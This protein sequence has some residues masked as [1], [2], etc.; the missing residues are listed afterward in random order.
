VTFPV[1]ARHAGIRAVGANPHPL[2]AGEGYHDW[3]LDAEPPCPADTLSAIN[4]SNFRGTHVLVGPHV[5]QVVALEN[6]SSARHSQTISAGMFFQAACQCC[7]AT[8]PLGRRC[9][10]TRRRHS[11]RAL[12]TAFR[13][14]R[15]DTHAW[16]TPERPRPHVGRSGRER[17]CPGRRCRRSPL[18][19]SL[20][21]PSRRSEFEGARPAGQVSI[22]AVD[23]NL[24]KL[25]QP[26]MPTFVTRR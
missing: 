17:H 11:S 6:P 25:F 24:G 1:S 26:T 19:E 7:S 10:A 5:P 12:I 4:R 8:G 16:P 20:A 21:P 18:T 23:G 14:Q 2:P 13:R 15:Y 22:N 3:F 9:R